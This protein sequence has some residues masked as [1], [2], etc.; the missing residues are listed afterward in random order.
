MKTCWRPQL[1]IAGFFFISTIL[2]FYFSTDGVA[3]R[4]VLDVDSL[5]SSS[6]W[7][8]GVSEIKLEFHVQTLYQSENLL[9]HMSD[10]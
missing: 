9:P 3:S 5:I 6:F 10:H 2:R 8:G 1:L 7:G 4:L